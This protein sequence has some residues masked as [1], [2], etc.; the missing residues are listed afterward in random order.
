MYCISRPLTR[1]DEVIISTNSRASIEPAVSAEGGGDLLPTCSAT[2]SGP[3]EGKLSRCVVAVG[4]G[5]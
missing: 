5:G 2:D 4:D 1:E 3:V